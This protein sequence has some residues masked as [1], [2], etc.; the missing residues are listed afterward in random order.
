MKNFTPL[1]KLY[2]S[3]NVNSKTLEEMASY[4]G[5]N[6][7]DV[8][9]CFQTMKLNGEYDKYRVSNYETVNAELEN[10]ESEMKQS[11]SANSL[12]D[13]NKLLFQQ[14]NAINDKSL[15]DDQFKQETERSK[16]VVSIAQTI[17]NNEKLLLEASKHFQRS[18]KQ[19]LE[20]LGVG[21]FDEQ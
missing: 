10:Y 21:G 12:L 6:K 13:L 17:I 5:C 7:R 14:L 1:E 15:T 11:E 20:V 16:V 8:K 2:I 18:E 19:V 9:S 3:K 4:L